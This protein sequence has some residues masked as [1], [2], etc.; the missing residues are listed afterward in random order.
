MPVER[1]PVS[2]SQLAELLGY[3]HARFLAVERSNRN[4][5]GWVIVTEGEDDMN[6]SGTFPQLTKGGKKVGGKKG[7]RGC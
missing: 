6:T 1:Y 4:D 5:R 7:K 2:H 3:D